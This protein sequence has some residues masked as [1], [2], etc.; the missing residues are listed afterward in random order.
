MR[1]YRKQGLEREDIK[2]RKCLKCQQQFP[3]KS[4]GNRICYSCKSGNNEDNYPSLG[5]YRLAL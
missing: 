5:T 3:S 4:I 1:K 2:Q